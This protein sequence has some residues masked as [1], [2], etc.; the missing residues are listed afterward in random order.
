M[1]N[2][3]LLDKDLKILS[4]P[5]H[6]LVA[7]KNDGLQRA[8]TGIAVDFMPSSAEIRYQEASICF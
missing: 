5:N 8:A 7:A 3:A 1:S 6:Y 4:L 2:L